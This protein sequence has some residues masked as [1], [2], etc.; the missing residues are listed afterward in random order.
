MALTCL[1]EFQEKSCNPF[2]LDE[3]CSNIIKCIMSDDITG[4]QKIMET[5]QTGSQEI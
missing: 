1:K 3:G 2:N 4:F 5:I